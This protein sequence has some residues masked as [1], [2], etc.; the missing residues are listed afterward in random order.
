M[1]KPGNNLPMN[2]GTNNR[3]EDI[4][5]KLNYAFVILTKIIE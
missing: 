1:D 4:S 3:R 5:F 2:E